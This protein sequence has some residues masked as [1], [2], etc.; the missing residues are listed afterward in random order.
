MEGVGRV[1]EG[2]VLGEEK[3]MGMGYEEEFFLGIKRDY[4]G[5]YWEEFREGG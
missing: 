3:Y 5:W 2:E 1:L 4:G